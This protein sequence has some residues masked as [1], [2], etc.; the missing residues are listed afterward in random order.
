MAKVLNLTPHPI[1]VVNAEN[2][3]VKTFQSDGLVR[4]KATTVNAGFIVDG[5]PV[6][7]TEFGEP[8]GLPEFKVGTFLIVSQLVKSA[9]SDRI[10]LVVP[11]EVVRD[12]TGNIIGCRSFGI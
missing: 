3:V 12:T 11:A 10:D 9:L 8:V 1:H 6:T 7:Q 4:L 5:V 2:N